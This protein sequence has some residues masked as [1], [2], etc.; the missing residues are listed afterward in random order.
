M[1][2][3]KTKYSHLTIEELLNTADREGFN[4]SE[5]GRELMHRLEELHTKQ[6]DADRQRA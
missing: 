6:L 2:V 3:H 1:L 5:L 4:L